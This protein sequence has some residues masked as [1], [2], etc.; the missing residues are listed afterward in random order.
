MGNDEVKSAADFYL[1]RPNL[2]YCGTMWS[3]HHK[4][5]PSPGDGPKTISPLCDEQI[6]QLQYRH[7]NARPPTVGN[8]R[9][10]GR[11]TK[12]KLTMVYEM[13]NDLNCGHASNQI[14]FPW[15]RPDTG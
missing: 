7:I 15:L 10:H 11:S 1:V 13:T 3:P 4:K 8:S 6:P 9:V 5:H 14:P 12:A 2:E